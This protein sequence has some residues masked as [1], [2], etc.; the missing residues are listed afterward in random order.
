MF[1]YS[2]LCAIVVAIEGKIMVPF[3]C[4]F[5]RNVCM[6]SFCEWKARANLFLRF[7]LF[8][9][10]FKQNSSNRSTSIKWGRERDEKGRGENCICSTVSYYYLSADSQIFFLVER[11][12]SHE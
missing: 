5:R 1:S 2:H 11:I 8:V 10:A 3:N 7:I 9:F 6:I 12:V 4:Q